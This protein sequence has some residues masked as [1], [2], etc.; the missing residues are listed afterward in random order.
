MTSRR[1][2]YVKNTHGAPPLPPRVV[3]IIR[4]MTHKVIASWRRVSIPNRLSMGHTLTSSPLTKMTFYYSFSD[5]KCQFLVAK[6]R[7]NHRFC[8]F[9]QDGYPFAL[10]RAR[11]G[12][13]SH[14]SRRG[15]ENEE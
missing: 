15:K 2:R 11:N 13:D 5:E 3:T 9:E 1:V 8:F 4:A 7:P 6:V 10:G 14:N 12:T